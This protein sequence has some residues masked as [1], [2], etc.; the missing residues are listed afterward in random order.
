MI[1]T[2][3]SIKQRLHELLTSEKLAVLSTNDG[4]QPYV[5]LVGFVATADLK[6]L[7]FATARNTRKY[8]NLKGNTHVALLIDN[9][10]DQDTDFQHTLAVTATGIAEEVTTQDREQWLPRYLAKH[11][12]LADFVNAPSCALIRVKV[13]W[14]YLVSHFQ[15]VLAVPMH[16]STQGGKI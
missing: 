16:A 8:A 3:E 9:R 10:S 5:N 13:A 11:P 1:D 2:R 12:H 15:S 6:Y 7:L 14:Y 4:E